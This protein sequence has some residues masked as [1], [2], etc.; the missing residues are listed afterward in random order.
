MVQIIII[1]KHHPYCPIMHIRGTLKDF[2]I[3][4]SN[5]NYTVTMVTT[6]PV[7]ILSFHSNYCFRQQFGKRAGT[8]I[9][10]QPQLT[11]HASTSN[12]RGLLLGTLKTS[13]HMGEEFKHQAFP[14]EFFMQWNGPPNVTDE[15]V[16]CSFEEKC[17]CG[18]QIMCL[19]SKYLLSEAL[20]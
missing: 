17:L 2:L 7:N 18:G 14:W 10:S 16:L 15:C 19:Y 4:R 13:S 1:C 5:T 12:A 20:L 11:T 8:K 3:T 6:V 9:R